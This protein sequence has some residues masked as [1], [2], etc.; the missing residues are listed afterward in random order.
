MRRILFL[1]FICVSAHG[2]NPVTTVRPLAVNKPDLVLPGPPAAKP[3]A[4][5]GA[6]TFQPT[7]E[8]Q[9]GARTYLL[10]IPAPRGQ[11]TDRNG[12]PLAQTRVS[13]NL[14]IAFPTPLAFDD[15]AL[16]RFTEQQIILARSLTGRP[17][18][19][20]EE[21]LL[22]HYKNRGVLPLIIAQD[23]KEFEVGKIRE[24]KSDALVLQPVY[25]RWYPQGDLAGH[26]I[27]Y[28][29][30]AGKMPDKIIENNDLLW[31]DSEGRDGLEQ[32][33]DDQ[34]KGKVGQLNLSFDPTG[35]KASEQVLLPPSPGY[36]VV[37]TLD[38][39]LQR[40]CEESLARNCKRGA[41]VFID[42]NQGDVLALASW[43][44][45]NPN[46]FVPTISQAD[47]DALRNNP[48]NP[49]IPRAYRSAYP[50]G[51][52]FKVFVGLAAMQGGKIAP[53]DTFNCPNAMEIGNLTFR[54]WK[55][56]GA[57]ELNFVEA[58]TQSCNTYFYQMGLRVGARPI[59][60]TAQ[61]LGLGVRTG[62]PLASETGGR[63]PTDDYMLKVYKRKFMPGDIANLSIGQGDTLISPLQMAQAIAAIGNG[64]TLLQMRLVQ[65]VQSLD[66]AIVTA[67][68][69]RARGVVEMD[70]QVAS[71]LRKGLIN[72][73]N[74]GS[75]TAGRASLDHV[76]VAGKTGT[77]Q[78]GPK[79]NERTA[80]WFVGFV[81][82]DKPR[83]AFAALYEGDANNDDVHGG[84][85]A[86][87]MI[88]QVLKQLYP[89]EK[90]VKK[91]KKKEEEASKPM[92]EKTEDG[93][94]V[95]RAEPV[96][97]EAN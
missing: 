46:W 19:I 31:P 49:L 80:A 36:N 63:I 7:W 5:P 67:Y 45:I 23:L 89:I 29:G 87:P 54:N 8:T 55:K 92:E 43:P 78:W 75:G 64:G 85:Q 95:R 91:A 39:G 13:Y 1:A 6:N 41:I 62:I 33:F 14:G 53:D 25:L 4:T 50:P 77:A 38:L 72:V 35:R 82:A 83:Y 11:I 24:Q 12:A 37:T 73:V 71:A 68:D 74:S 94:P 32:M 96:K 42:A 56:E 60:E 16:K 61:R 93:T 30:R 79:N 66:S 44:P 69:A 48:E 88:G 34:L 40:M 28:A 17:I 27:G 65:Q 2:Q 90:K 59:Y 47:F 52:T 15:T 18:S 70:K 20:G 3:V 58:L 97:P 84:T 10:G 21:A 9:K 51:S 86:A 76:V 26:V 22:K 81:P 57:G